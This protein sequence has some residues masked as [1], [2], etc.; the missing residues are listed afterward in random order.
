MCNSDKTVLFRA[1]AEI[2]VRRFNL[3]FLEAFKNYNFLSTVAH[4][5]VVFSLFHAY[6]SSLPKQGSLSSAHSCCYD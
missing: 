4:E 5:K 3:S 2:K 6:C 1:T